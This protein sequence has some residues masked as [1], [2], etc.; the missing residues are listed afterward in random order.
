VAVKLVIDSALGQY[1]IKAD[2]APDAPL[3][4]SCTQPALDAESVTLLMVRV[5]VM[6]VMNANSVLESVDA[7]PPWVASV[8]V[9]LV[10]P[11]ESVSFSSW[12]GD[13]TGYAPIETRM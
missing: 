9:V 12:I 6:Q 3:P 8:K 11:A 7:T 13:G 1:Q 2:P 10:A 5:L 4:S